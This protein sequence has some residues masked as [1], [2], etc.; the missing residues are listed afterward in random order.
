MRAVLLNAVFVFLFQIQHMAFRGLDCGLVAKRGLATKT[1]H[2]IVF[3]SAASPRGGSQAS[4]FVMMNN[5]LE[6]GPLS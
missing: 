2:R 1:G 4:L 3:V 5:W 6:V